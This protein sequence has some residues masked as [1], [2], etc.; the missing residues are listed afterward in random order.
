MELPILP[1]EI[2]PDYGRIN[3]YGGLTIDEHNKT[4][5]KLKLGILY[6][7]Y[8]VAI[9]KKPLAGV[10]LPMKP[11]YSKIYYIKKNIDRKYNK[12]KRAF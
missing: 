10:D 12:G 1:N 5:D 3:K 9:G 7:I 2:Y 4:Y 8:C 11:S 6:D